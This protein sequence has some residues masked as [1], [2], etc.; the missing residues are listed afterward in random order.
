MKIFLMLLNSLPA[1]L[2]AVLTVQAA[3]P[4]VP[5]ASKKALFFNVIAAA[6]TVAAT[7]P[8]KHVQAISELIDGTVKTLNATNM[9][10]FG[11]SKPTPIPVVLE[12]VQVTVPVPEP[13]AIMAQSVKHA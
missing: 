10:G 1:I 8:E 12:P 5:G 6:N 2:Q 4:G 7:I 13:I 11:T 3:L 9:L